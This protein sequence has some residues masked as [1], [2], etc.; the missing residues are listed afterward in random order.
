MVLLGNKVDLKD[1]REVSQ[2][3]VRAKLEETTL[4]YFEVSA[5]TGLNIK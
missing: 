2:E 4:P 5:K 3:K 1:E